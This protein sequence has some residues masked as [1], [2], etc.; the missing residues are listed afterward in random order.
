[1][2]KKGLGKGLNTLFVE[3]PQIVDESGIIEVK[4]TEVMP[5]PAQPRKTFDKDKLQLLADS[6]KENGMIQPIIV[7]KNDDFGYT[8]VAGERRW[9]ATKLAGIKTV[10]VVIKEYDDKTVAEVALI[11]NLQREDLNPIE[12]ALG[13]KELSEKYSMKQEEISQ[14]VGKSRSAIAN[15]MRLLSLEE[16]F[17]KLLIDGQISEG[18]ARAALAL[19]DYTLREFLLNQVVNQ[20]LNVRQTE[21]LVRQLQKGKPEKKA[22]KPDVY[23]IELERI[24]TRLSSNLGT[25][26]K[27]SSGAKKGKIEIEFYGNDDLDRL[28]NLIEK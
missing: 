18:H 11:E 24:E 17:Q 1:M 10:P 3:D 22:K 19:E 25:K 23:A 27:I 26:V 7:T 28:L 14:K 2:A 20:E 13:Y 6:I 8:I 9:R 4:V 12:E 15:A 16:A 5:N 21:T